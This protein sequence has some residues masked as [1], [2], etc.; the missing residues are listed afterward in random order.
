MA[1]TLALTI[2]LAFGIAITLLCAWGI[3]NPGKLMNIV[4]ATWN[5][6]VGMPLAIG[7]RL[8]LGA[9]LLFSAPVSSFPATFRLL[10]VIA[11]LAAIGLP[12]A[13]RE[14]V[15]RLIAWGQKFPS[16]LLRCWLLLGIVFGLFLVTGAI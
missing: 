4:L 7:T 5:Q 12:L 13:G 11:L 8:A 6:P 16:G 1:Q 15:N 10:G 14:R 9:C 2:V 3:L